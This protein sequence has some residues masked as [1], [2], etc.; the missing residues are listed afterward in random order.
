[1]R[2]AGSVGGVCGPH[3]SGWLGGRVSG[4]W[5]RL[6]RWS[7]C[8]G[9]MGSLA[10][11][12]GCRAPCASRGSMVG[13]FGPHT[14]TWLDGR[15]PS[16]TNLA[17]PDRSPASGR[18]HRTV[19]RSHWGCGQPRDPDSPIGY[20]PPPGD[21][22]RARLVGGCASIDALRQMRARAGPS[23]QVGDWG[24]NTPTI[25]L[26]GCMEPTHPRP[27]SQASPWGPNTPRPPSHA[28]HMGPDTPATVPG[29]PMG[30][31]VEPARGSEPAAGQPQRRRSC[32]A[33]VASSS[34]TWAA[35]RTWRVAPTPWPA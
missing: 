35:G 3:V 13:V 28:K 34:M 27:P 30:P 26:G 31:R 2:S 10:R 16:C 33:P 18:G 7:G 24:P 11:W 1:M 17:Q 12:P 25:E 6:S 15:G 19:G 29:E 14:P 20:A 21:C 9:P 23:S 5:A 32:S 22:A 8:S 4:P